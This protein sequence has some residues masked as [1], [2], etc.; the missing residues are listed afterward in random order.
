MIGGLGVARRAAFIMSATVRPLCQDS[1]RLYSIT[2]R[3]SLSIR[4]FIST[5]FSLFA[6]PS[7]AGERGEGR[8]GYWNAVVWKDT[9]IETR[10]EVYM[11]E[12]KQH[13]GVQRE[14]RIVSAFISK[15]GVV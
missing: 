6:P 9:L 5:H 14:R 8:L 13:L 12:P 11:G 4:I 10:F 3:R 15:G 7:R 1:R 2:G